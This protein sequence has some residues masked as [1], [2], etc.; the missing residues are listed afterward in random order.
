MTDIDLLIEQAR[1]PYTQAEISVVNDHAVSLSVFEGQ[2]PWHRH[3]ESDETFVCLRGCLVLEVEGQL[4]VRL[5]PGGVY[6]V[7]AG[8]AHRSRGEGRTANLSIGVRER[9]T[10]MLE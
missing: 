2:Y 3:P 1:G 10:E 4:E 6:T 9:V 5:Q 8:V 7:P